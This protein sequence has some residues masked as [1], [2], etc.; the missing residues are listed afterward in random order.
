MPLLTTTIGAYPKPDYL[1]LPDWFRVGGPSGEDPTAAY[2]AYLKAAPADLQATLDRATREAVAEQVAAGIDVPSEG[3]LRRDNYI[4]YHCRHL[5]G[6]D[7]ENLVEKA[8]RTGAWTARVPAVTGPIA[9][10]APFLVE[11]WR[12]AQAASERPVKITLP[13]PLTVADTVADRYYGD[14]RQLGAAMAEALNVEVRA[15]AAA[16][17]RWIQIDEPLFARYPEKALAFG[18]DNLER[19]FEGT[20]PEVTRVVHMCCGYPDKLDE[21]DYLKADRGAYFALAEAL[22]QSSIHAVSIEDAHR[23]NELSLLE[24]FP[25]KTVILGAVAIARSRVETVEEIRERLSGALQHIDAGR[26]MAAPD[27]G[28]GMLPPETVQAKLRN[29]TAAARAVG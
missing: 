7:F 27:C 25:S 2:T 19:A 11:D 22:E 6:F 1:D 17:C 13:G 12:R 4:H 20:P 26:L 14:E 23:H 29:M 16:G 21:T 15:L 3:E 24:H 8:M 10:G 18:L 5:K 9:A 28:L